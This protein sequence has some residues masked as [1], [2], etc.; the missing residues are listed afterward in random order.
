M[1]LCEMI[2]F[3]ILLVGIDR[4]TLRSCVSYFD[5][6]QSLKID[7]FSHMKNVPTNNGQQIKTKRKYCE[8]EFGSSVELR[9]MHFR[10]WISSVF[11]ELLVVV[12]QF[13]ISIVSH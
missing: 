11:T 7:F 9:K 10:Y 5:T 3:C 13:G 4:I 6:H 2:F 12:F 8:Y 1:K